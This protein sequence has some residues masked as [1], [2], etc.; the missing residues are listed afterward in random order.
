M[1]K[2]FVIDDELDNLTVFSILFKTIQ[3]EHGIEYD[4]KLLS[5]K[6]LTDIETT[7]LDEEPDLIFLDIKLPNRSGIEIYDALRTLGYSN[8]IVAQT[9]SVT[10]SEVEVFL[11]I[12]TDGLLKKPIDDE[13]IVKILKKHGLWIKIKQKE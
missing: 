5:S 7:I 13:K 11:E 3:I 12:F 2:I 10:N 1:Y 9:A 6:D 8:P 4:L